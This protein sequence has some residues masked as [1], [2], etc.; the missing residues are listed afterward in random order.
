M[1]RSGNGPNADFRRN[2]KQ[3]PGR[4]EVRLQ[5]LRLRLQQLLVPIRPLPRLSPLHPAHLPLLRRQPLLPLQ[6][7]LLQGRIPR[8]RTNKASSSAS[9]RHCCIERSLPSG[10]PAPALPTLNSPFSIKQLRKGSSQECSLWSLQALQ[11]IPTQPGVR[12]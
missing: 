2:R 9:T 5:H 1:S 6:A 3:E 10:F 4:I 8:S 11:Q 12:G 7:P